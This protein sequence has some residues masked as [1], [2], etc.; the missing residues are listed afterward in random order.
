MKKRIPPALALFVLAP[1]I[2]ELI[3]GSAPPAEFFN[4]LTF[5]VRAASP[6]NQSALEQTLAHDPDARVGLCHYRRGFDGQ[7]VL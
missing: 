1:A 4:P 5:F 6:R 2:G 3:S 7:I